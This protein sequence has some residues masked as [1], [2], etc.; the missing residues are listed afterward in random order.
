MARDFAGAVAGPCG[1]RCGKIAVDAVAAVA[2]EPGKM[3]ESLGDTTT[4]SNIRNTQNESTMLCT[5]TN[6][7]KSSAQ[8]TTSGIRPESRSVEPPALT[9]RPAVCELVAPALLT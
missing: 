4:Q 5:T 7:S 6:S 3:P 9:F 8:E 2:H 1:R